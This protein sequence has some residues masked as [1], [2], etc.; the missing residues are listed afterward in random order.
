MPPAEAAL[1]GAWREWLVSF[2]CDPDRTAMALA[3]MGHT[4]TL[5]LG[6]TVMLD[7]PSRTAFRGIRETCMCQYA[8]PVKRTRYAPGLRQRSHM[9]GAPHISLVLAGDCQEESGR[10]EVVFGAGSLALRPEGMRHAVTFSRRGALILTCPLPAHAGIDAPRWSR[11]LP[12]EHLRALTPL[13]VSDDAEAVEAG[14]DLIALAE[15][16]PSRRPAADWLL[17]VR[18][19]LIEEPAA[20]ISTI[21]A[22]YGRHRVHLGRAFLAAFG[23]TPSAF[24]RRAMLDRALCAMT[25]GVPAAA[26]AAE[27]GF[28]DQSHFNRTCRDS[29]GLTP[30]QLTR[31][32]ADVAS[33]QYARA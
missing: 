17:A 15:D 8:A 14:W 2:K 1:A 19:Q 5:M 18:D 30:R 21:A 22:Q 3:G 28:A 29:F 10:T 23:E 31:G 33:V 20:D 25:C 4:T 12:R 16:Q 24:R 6:G 27:G 32:A 26:A 11:A 13:L 7:A 9:H